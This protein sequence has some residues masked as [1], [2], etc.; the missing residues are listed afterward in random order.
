MFSINEKYFNKSSNQ[1]IYQYKGLEKLNYDINIKSQ[2]FFICMY[3]I[4][5]SELYPFLEFILNNNDDCLSLIKLSTNLKNTENIIDYALQFINNLL[6]LN[7][8]LNNKLN[9]DKSIKQ[10]EYKG[11][12]YYKNNTYLFFD[13]T[14]HKIQIKHI[15]KKSPLWFVLIDEIINVL[16]SIIPIMYLLILSFVVGFAICLWLILILFVIINRF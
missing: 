14:N 4:N 12:L 11:C 5:N 10:N 9:N 8:K 15:Y 13:I 2:N 7:N 6:N 16:C 3:Q 1:N